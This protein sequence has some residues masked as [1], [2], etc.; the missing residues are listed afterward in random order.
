M[1]AVRIGAGMG[2]YGDRT[3]PSLALA[4]AGDVQ[5]ICFD[6]LAELTM[7]I[8]EKDRARDPDAGYTKDVVPLMRDLLPRSHPRGIRL[9][10]NAGGVNP[11]AAA[12]AV[13]QVAH[14]LGIADLKV[15]V[16][17]GDDLLGR[18]EE[19]A[20]PTLDIRHMETGEPL[21][22]VRDRLVFANAYLGA[23]PI[24]E[25]LDLGAEVVIT[26]RTTD[27]A[28]FL[29]PLRHSF[30]WAD[31]DYARLAGGIV[32][33]H[34]L[35]CGG[36]VTGGNFSGDWQNVPDLENLGYPIAEVYPDGSAVI[37]K[38][39]GTGG[40]VSR[41]TV[42]EQLLYEI[43]D[44]AAYVTPDV[45]VDFTTVR[46]EDVGP[47]RVRVWGATGRPAPP[48]LKLLAGYRVGFLGE[49][50]MGYAWPQALEKARAAERIIRRQVEM[51]GIRV[52]EIAASYL[53]YD[54]LHGPLATPPDEDALNEVYLRMAVRTESRDEALRFERL[55]PPLALT[56][57]P[58]IGGLSGLAPVRELFGLWSALVP[59]QQVEPR[60]RVELV[61][62]T[63]S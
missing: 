12:R 61:G 2:F 11:H 16:V 9:V 23:Q 39:P 57:P 28:Q 55:F 44:P 17:T 31:D 47:D 46:L 53:G 45:V 37:E 4:E 5:F 38:P 40:R 20:D 34:L 42:K 30:G 1:D 62:G 19:L 60:V 14:T 7:A 48:T 49:G 18:L 26:G 15:A 54:S 41:D 56:G 29:G 63:A 25:A 58:F 6:D 33:G 3:W 43:H 10:T 8:L 59:R 35:E 52:E 27:T 22:A 50:T 21:A 24:V 36:Q 51:L 13:K 32:V